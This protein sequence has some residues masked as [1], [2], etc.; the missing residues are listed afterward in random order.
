MCVCVGVGVGLASA[1]FIVYERLGWVTERGMGVSGRVA[2]R[3]V[4]V[5][6]D[7]YWRAAI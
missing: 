2:N 6:V 1:W 7:D 4:C 3:E 5:N